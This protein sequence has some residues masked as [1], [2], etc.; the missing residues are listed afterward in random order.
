MDALLKFFDLVPHDIPMI[1]VGGVLFV[2]LWRALDA[3]F[4]GPLKTLTE[5]REAATTGAQDQAKANLAKENELNEQ[6]NRTIAEA[7]AEAVK[8][9]IAAVLKA[10]QEASKLILQAETEAQEFIKKMRSETIA[11]AT[12]IQARMEEELDPLSE[13]IVSRILSS[14]DVTSGQVRG[15]SGHSV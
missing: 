4:F 8:E 3:T 12:E 13:Q 15:S 1:I 14:D 6:R 7:R 5:T 11:R 2:G 9:K 10:K